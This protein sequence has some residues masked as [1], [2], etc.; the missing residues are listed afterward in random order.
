MFGRREDPARALEL[1]DPPEPLEPRTVEKVLLGN[2][3]GGQVRSG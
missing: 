2:V 1:A 3:L